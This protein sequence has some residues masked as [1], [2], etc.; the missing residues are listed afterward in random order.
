MT[1]FAE[2]RKQMEEAQKKAMEQAQREPGAAAESKPNGQQPQM[3]VDY[4]LKESGAKKAI[5][6]FDAARS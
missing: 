4:S 1:T 2:M 5:N 6:G 3:E